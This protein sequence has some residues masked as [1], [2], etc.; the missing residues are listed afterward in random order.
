VYIRRILCR[1]DGRLLSHIDLTLSGTEIL[2][3]GRYYGEPEREMEITV[4][5]CIFFSI[6]SS[7]RRYH[8][9]LGVQTLIQGAH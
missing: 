5:H 6:S 8:E 2:V 1:R 9:S 4:P 7:K 3:C